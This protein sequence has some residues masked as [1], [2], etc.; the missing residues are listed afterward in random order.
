MFHPF[1]IL[2][3]LRGTPTVQDVTTET[4]TYYNE[5]IH[6]DLTFRLRPELFSESCSYTNTEHTFRP[7][8][9]KHKIQ[10]DC[11]IKIFF[12]KVCAVL[13][14]NSS[15]RIEVKPHLEIISRLAWANL[16]CK[17][18]L[19]STFELFWFMGFWARARVCVY[20]CVCVCG[21]VL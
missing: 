19:P 21:C 5:H 9:F 15:P 2:L 18:P 12:F 13:L 8:R 4:I 20:V 6:F 17:H 16:Q 10:L 1:V 11:K 14:Q 7:I 3:R